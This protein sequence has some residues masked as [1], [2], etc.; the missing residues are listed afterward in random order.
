MQAPDTHR[1]IQAIWRI[2]GARLTAGLARMLRD[3][4]AAEELAQEAFMTALERWPIS[5]VPDKPGA[6]LMAT[7]K[8]R[9]IDLIRHRDVAARKSAELG[10][11]DELRQDDTMPDIEAL[12][13][14]IGDEILS[15]MFTAC[16]PVLANEGRIAMTLRLIGGLTTDEI[17]RAFMVP[18]PTVAQRIVR[19]K[20]AL[21]DAGVPYEVP[22]GAARSDRLRSVL[23]VV[24]LIFNEGYSATAG[25]DWVRPSLCHEALRLGRVLA[26]LA[27]AEPEIHGLVALMEFQASRLGARVDAEGNAILLPDQDRNRWDRLHIRLGFE[28]LARA[29]R[30]TATPGI[31]HYQAAIAACHARAFES[32]DTDW[33][34]IDRLYTALTQLMPTPVVRLNH[35]V[36]IS[37]ARG[38]ADAL[39]LVDALAAEPLLKSYH[40]LPGIRGD[41]LFKLGRMEEAKTEFQRAA[42]MAGNR[43]EKDFL[44]RRA[45]QCKTSQ[46]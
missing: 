15:L 10:Y 32:A 29:D 11:Q 9:A 4:G 7:A 18:E 2:E 12:D 20:R 39:I 35:A 28:A 42:A 6:W 16:H 30:L 24:Y 45:D 40:F 22:H 17:A 33:A 8:R 3:S 31:Y 5:G 19:A 13:D 27:P 34:E 37:M 36:A 23:E 25:D 46:K 38:P 41:L 14:D 26:G 44:T 43:R 21:S 1:V